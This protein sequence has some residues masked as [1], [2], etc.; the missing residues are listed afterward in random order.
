MKHIF[1]L[2]LALFCAGAQARVV[3][4]VNAHGG[5]VLLIDSL[6]YW[7]GEHRP[8]SGFTTQ[9]GVELYTSRDLREWHDAGAVLRVSEE[10]GSPIERGCIIE[11]PKV[12]YCQR[13]RQYVMLFHLERKGR[14]YEA[15]QVGFAVSARP[16]GPFTFVRALRPNAGRWPREFKKRDIRTALAQRPS[17]YKEWWTPEWREAIRKGMFTARDLEGGQMSRDQTVFVDRDGTA[18]QI[19][20]S[21]DNLTLHINEL[22]P[23]YLGFT[24]RYTRVAPGG[25]NEAPTLM[26]HDGTYWLITSGCTGWAPNEARMFSAKSIWGPW[27]QHPS[28]FRGA[29]AERTFGG[30]GTYI[31]GQTFMADVWNPRHLSDSQHLWLPIRFEGGVP[32]IEQE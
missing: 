10:A 28:P 22:T 26:L 3:T 29:G 14:G 13:T 21:E 12:V 4:G 11:R 32:V 30:Q 7:Y 19:T 24:G 18:Y 15:A 16:E 5:C 31:F 25:Q 9:V 8:S 6:Y 17:D 23:D 20:S 2:F 1:F 27:T